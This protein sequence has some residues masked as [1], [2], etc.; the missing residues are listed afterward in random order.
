MTVWTFLYIIGCGVSLIMSCFG[1]S[2]ANK[3][4]PEKERCVGGLVCACIICSL[5]SWA[6]PIW[7]VGTEIYKKS[8][9]K[10]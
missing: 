2:E 6:I 3:Q 4:M 7:W 10:K 8:G 9:E 5:L 1:L